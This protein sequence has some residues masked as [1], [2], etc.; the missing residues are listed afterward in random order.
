[1]KQLFYRPLPGQVSGEIC[2]GNEKPLKDK[3]SVSVISGEK[4]DVPQ[5][6]YT[7]LLQKF[8]PGGSFIIQDEDGKPLYELTIKEVKG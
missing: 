5:S 6:F 7:C 2:F 4:I 1:M 3:Q 8:P